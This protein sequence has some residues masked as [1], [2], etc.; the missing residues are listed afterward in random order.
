V[1][2]TTINRVHSLTTLSPIKQH[3][4]HGRISGITT[5]MAAAK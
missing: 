1:Q 4:Q 3:K 5:V 2:L